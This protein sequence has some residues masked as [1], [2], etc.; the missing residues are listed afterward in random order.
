MNDEVGELLL[1]PVGLAELSKFGITSDGESADILFGHSVE[2]YCEDGWTVEKRKAMVELIADYEKTVDGKITHYHPRDSS[3]LKKI[4]GIDWIAYFAGLAETVEPDGE[5]GFDATVYGFA[6]GEDEDTATPY[7][8]CVIGSPNYKRLSR[9]NAYFPIDWFEADH[10]YESYIRL[11]QRWCGLLK[12][13]HGTA[14]F[15]IIL[16]EGQSKSRGALIAFPFLKRFPGLDLPNSSRWS[17]NVRGAERRHVRSINWLTAIDDN[18]VEELG[19]LDRV[20]ESV[21]KSCLT[22]AYSGGIIIQA[23]PRP[24]IGDINRGLIP[25]HYKTVAKLLAPLRF[26]DFNP[27]L[28]YLS[29]PKPLDSLDETLKWIRRFD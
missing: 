15:S 22:H 20:K 16:E 26:E 23:G 6:G 25:E 24:E 13:S 18:F 5:E 21:G 3:R 19:G 8:C 27:R 7:F 29:V 2:L 1:N 9:A 12:V 10:G 11:M 14:G 17:S 4:G 28:P